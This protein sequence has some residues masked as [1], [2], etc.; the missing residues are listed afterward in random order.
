MTHRSAHEAFSPIRW[1]TALAGALLVV[2]AVPSARANEVAIGVSASQYAV[3]YEGTGGHTL[4]I[5]NV[6]INGNVGVGG[7][8][9]S[10]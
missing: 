1:A 7:N 6:T 5:T 8:H 3:L 10:Q 9:C 4:H 2:L